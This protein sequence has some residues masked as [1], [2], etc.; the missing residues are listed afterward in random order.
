MDQ[1]RVIDLGDAVGHP[2]FPSTLEA[3]VAGRGGTM[4]EA[5]YHAAERPGAAEFSVGSPPLAAPLIP[6]GARHPILGPREPLPWPPSQAFL[7]HSPE[8]G[9]LVG[10]EGR[11]WSAKQARAAIFGYLLVVRW[12]RATGRRSTVAVSL[13]P[14]LATPEDV[15]LRRGGI[16]S[17]VNGVVCAASRLHPARW[18]LPDLVAERSRQPSG[19]RAGVLVTSALGRSTTGLGIPL[20]PDSVVEV[21][22]DGLGAITTRLQ[23]SADRAVE[24]SAI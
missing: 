12:M 14:W 3:L 24:R 8:L 17:T 18:I 19:I 22:A 6:R 11:H 1:G 21:E 5:A 9:A 13:G 7:D 20:E 10:R 15:D 2:A 23:G 4:V 16:R